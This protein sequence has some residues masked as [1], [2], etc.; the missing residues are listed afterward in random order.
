MEKLLD[1]IASRLEIRLT[2]AHKEGQ[3]VVHMPPRV[4]F[5]LKLFEHCPVDERTRTMFKDALRKHIAKKIKEANIGDVIEYLFEYGQVYPLGEIQ[6]NA[7]DNMAEVL[8]ELPALGMGEEY[9][10]PADTYFSFTV[11]NKQ[12]NSQDLVVGTRT[13]LAIALMRH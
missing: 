7:N 1:A 5:A 4:T 12:E 6:D 3:E 13:W 9:V 11:E 2:V 10:L 8:R